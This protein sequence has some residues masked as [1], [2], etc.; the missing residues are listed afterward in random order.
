VVTKE[1]KE[2]LES[3]EGFTYVP[4]RMHDQFW[5]RLMSGFAEKKHQ[6]KWAAKIRQQVRK[7]KLNEADEHETEF[8]DVDLLLSEFLSEFMA[9]KAN[10]RKGLLK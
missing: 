9:A 6:T 10:Y 4:W 7:T 8:I 2:F 5:Q 1:R 3:P